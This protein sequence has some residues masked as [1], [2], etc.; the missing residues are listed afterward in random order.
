VQTRTN[1]VVV[2]PKKRKVGCYDCG[3]EY[4]GDAWIE[5]IIPDR[6]W[7]EIRPD[8]CEKGCGILCISCIVKRLREKGFRNIPIWLCGTEPI[9]AIPGSPGDCL[10]ILR[11]WEWRR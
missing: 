1:G 10:P 3:L 2:V 7:D 9:Q 5:A 8:G 4:G 11:Y 6:V